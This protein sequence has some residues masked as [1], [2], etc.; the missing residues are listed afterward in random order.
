[1]AQ[2]RIVISAAVVTVLGVVA[3]WQLSQSSPS[4]TDGPVH[5]HGLGVNPADAALFIATH[6]G[7]W[8]LG[9]DAETSTRVGESRQDT[10][11]F[12]IVGSNAFLGSGHPELRE[13][14]PP[15]LGLIESTD[16]GATWRSVSLLGEADFHVL[17]S[18]GDRLYGYDATGGRLLVSGD[19]GRTWIE[20][21]APGS[22]LDL[23]VDPSD[24]ER[25]VAASDRGLHVSRNGGRSWDPVATAPRLL[26]WPTVGRL[27]LAGAAGEVFV[28]TDGGSTVESVGSVGAEPA[29]LL[30]V[31]SDE[32]YVALHDGTIRYSDDGGVT[33]V[34]RAT[35]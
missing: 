5:V 27:Y 8:R 22:L 20:L 11:G 9:T 33:W 12:T 17:R 19:R 16:A 23:A 15:L 34:D 7:L 30:A 35:P 13:D 21:E 32:L 29:A 18:T 10:M 4:S 24:S 26:A 1:M 31:G 28:S 6:T 3:L 25:L 14:L 2:A